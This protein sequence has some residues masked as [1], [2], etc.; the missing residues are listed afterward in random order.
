MPDAPPGGVLQAGF[1][2]WNSRARDFGEIGGIYARLKPAQGDAPPSEATIEPDFPG[3]VIASFVVPEGGPGDVEV[4]MLIDA[5]TEAG[6]GE[7]DAPFDLRRRAAEADPA[8]L[9]TAQFLPF[10]GDTVAGRT[11]SGR[12]QHPAARTLGLHRAATARRPGGR[13]EPPRRAGLA[14]APLLP[15]AQPGTPAAG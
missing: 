3:H 4:G 15:G 5:C 12:G 14:S 8:A 6:C 9:V 1:T 10:V 11:F 13:R 7:A 2:F